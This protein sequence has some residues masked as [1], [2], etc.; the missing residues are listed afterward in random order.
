[1]QLLMCISK[2]QS[3][4]FWSHS[5]E[6]RFH[7]LFAILA[8]KA[9]LQVKTLESI[10]VRWDGK[11]EFVGTSF[12]TPAPAVSQHVHLK[13]STSW[14]CIL[15]KIER[16]AEKLFLVLNNKRKKWARKNIKQN[17]SPHPPKTSV[18]SQF[19]SRH[20]SGTKATGGKRYYINRMCSSELNKFLNILHK[21]GTLNDA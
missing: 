12:I 11:A 17:W 10:T 1:M 7:Y 8:I 9:R 19:S 3:P 14:I 13:L 16:F 4:P 18:E 15:L 21:L 6:N 20:L 5:S 2:S